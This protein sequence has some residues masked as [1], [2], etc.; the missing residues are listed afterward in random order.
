VR[1]KSSSEECRMQNDDAEET[2]SLLMQGRFPQLIQNLKTFRPS[3]GMMPG[4]GS[5]AVPG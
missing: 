5:Y 1:I 3:R 2:I 4:Q